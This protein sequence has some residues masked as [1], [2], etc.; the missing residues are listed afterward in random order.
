MR[1]RRCGGFMIM[2]PV[3]DLNGAALFIEMRGTRCVNC[4]NV[5]D[6]VITA[7][8]MESCPIRRSPRHDSVTEVPVIPLMREKLR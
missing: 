2:E 6:A 3:Y 4:G 5:E 1:C 7:N 8:R